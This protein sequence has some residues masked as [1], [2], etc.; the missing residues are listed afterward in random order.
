MPDHQYITKIKNVFENFSN[1]LKRSENFQGKYQHNE[2]NSDK[3]AYQVVKY[4]SSVNGLQS[5]NMS[6]SDL[7]ITIIIND[8]MLNHWEVLGDI[9]QVIEQQNESPG[10]PRYKLQ[11]NTPSLIKS[12]WLLKFT[13]TY[14]GVDIDIMVNRISEI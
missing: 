6:A 3:T 12:G 10:P 2:G 5:K 8:T 13:D 1:C 11:Q 14:Y 7:D 4:G 9:K